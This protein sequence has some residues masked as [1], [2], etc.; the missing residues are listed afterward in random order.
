MKFDHSLNQSE[1]PIVALYSTRR[2]GNAHS[3]LSSHNGFHLHVPTYPALQ[4]QHQVCDVH[5]GYQGTWDE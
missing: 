1:S 2:K 5:A 3:D 4:E